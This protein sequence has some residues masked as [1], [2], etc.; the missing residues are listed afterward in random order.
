MGWPVWTGGGTALTGLSGR[1]DRF[2]VASAGY[3]EFFAARGA[4]PERLRVTGIP[5]F[6]DC[7]RYCD[8]DLPWRGYVLACTSDLRETFHRDDRQAFIARVLRIAGGRP[9]H[10]KLHPN[11]N[12]ARARRE[13]ARWAPHA[14]VHTDV[15]AEL[16]VA[17]CDVLVTQASSVAFVGIALGKVVHSDLDVA[18]LRRLCP[19]QNGGRSAARIAEV[20]RELLASPSPPVQPS[21]VVSTP[22]LQFA[23]VST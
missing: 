22:V 18:Q 9:V 6:D 15:S 10:F 21:E 14:H 12:V 3:R 5:N 13:I 11:E 23:E 7:Q 1:Y 4:P 8:N 19:E 16:L 20:C 2:C 17:N